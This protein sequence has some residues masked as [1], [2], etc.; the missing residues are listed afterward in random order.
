MDEI[1]RIAELRELLEYHNRRYYIDNAPEIGDIEFDA[2][3]H[4]L[5]RLESLHPECYDPNSP[6]CR[7]G[8]DLSNSFEQVEHE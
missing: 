4:E 6:T 1:Q 2:L 3:M 8:A 7:V 5:E